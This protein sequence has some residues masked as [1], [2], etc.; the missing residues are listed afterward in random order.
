MRTVSAPHRA[1]LGG[2]A[3]NYHLRVEIRNESGTW[4]DYTNDPFEGYDWVDEMTLLENIDQP[5]V[6]GTLRLK[7]EIVDGGPSI[8]SLAPFQADS[9]LNVDDL[10]AYS[11]VIHPGRECRAWVAPVA[12]GVGRPADVSSDWKKIFDGY[13]GKPQWG[14][15]HTIDVILRGMGALLADAIIEEEREYGSATVPINVADVMQQI[16]DD[17]GFGAVTIVV[18]VPVNWYLEP[19]TQARVPVFEAIR[20]LA[21]QIGHDLRYIYPAAGTIPELT[22]Y[23]PDRAPTF[24]DLTNGIT[25]T[26]DEYAKVTNLEIGD[27]EVRNFGRIIFNDAAGTRNEVTAIDTASINTFGRRYIEIAEAHTSNIDTLQEAQDMIDAVIAD[28]A[29]PFADHAI[30]TFLLWMLQLGDLVHFAANNV[31]YSDDQEYAIVQIAHRFAGGH[32]DTTIQ[33]R[34]KPAGAYRNWIAMHGLGPGERDGIPA[35]RF[36][37]LLGEDSEGGGVSGQVDGMAWIGVEFDPD[38]EYVDVYGEE[39]S[40]ANTPTPDISANALCLRLSRP[41]GDIG[42]DPRWKTIIGIATRPFRFR[43]VRACG[44]SAAGRKGPDWIPPAVEAADPT[45]T[46]IDGVVQGF[47]INPVA[48]QSKNVLHVTPGTLEPSGGNF[49]A[50]RRDGVDLTQ[51]HIGADPTARFI[52]DTSINPNARYTYEAYI[53]NNGVSGKRRR[54][55]VGLPTTPDFDFAEQTPRLV[56]DNVLG[57][58]VVRIAWA[59]APGAYLTADH[60]VIE[61]GKNGVNFPSE[62]VTVPVGSSPYYDGNTKTKYYRLRL[63]DAANAILAYSMPGYLDGS[64]IPPSYGPAALP[65]WDPVPIGQPFNVGGVLGTALLI[66]FICPTSGAVECSIEHSLDN[67]AT[68]PW[69][70]DFRS[71]KL[72]G[73]KWFGDPTILQYYRLRAIGPGDVT[74]T[75]SGSKYWNGVESV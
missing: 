6:S 72:S 9:I 41:E 30:E 60:V 53:W 68:D 23:A 21:L 22:F 59:I 13:L 3:L 37:F 57:K 11:P 64:N 7:R 46:P 16:L 1:L 39:G 43:K 17:N 67:G 27:D 24:V 36:T 51:V 5:I 69:T 44:F 35:P 34:G 75:V 58:N 31:H 18:P 33:T 71:A 2:Q 50:I 45:P 32:A 52:E 42:Q 15:D 25:I 55:G 63:E 66:G 10:S 8:L 20:A 28:L 38:T 47:T 49:I 14:P 70:E 74:I 54:H 56:W 73:D 62:L 12:N 48:V 26:A 19:Y 4:I 61:Y 29:T 65:I 40:T